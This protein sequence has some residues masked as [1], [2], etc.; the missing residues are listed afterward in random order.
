MPPPLLLLRT[1]DQEFVLSVCVFLSFLL[2]SVVGCI[3]WSPRRSDILQRLFFSVWFI[4]QNHTLQVHPCCCKRWNFFHLFF[5]WLSSIALCMYT[6]LLYTFMCKWTLRLLPYL[7]NCKS[8]CCEH[9][10]ACVFS[11]YCFSFIYMY[12]GVELLGHVVILLFVCLSAP[13]LSCS[14]WDL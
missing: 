7:E 4:S 2:G 5:L 3:F 12:S 13:D 9:Q 11:N 14:K 6:H 1:D 8:C 10:S